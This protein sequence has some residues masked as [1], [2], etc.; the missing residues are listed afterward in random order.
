MITDVGMPEM[1]GWQLAERIKGTYSGMKVAVVTGWGADASDEEKEKYGVAYILG[2][3][4]DMAQ[5]KH[6]VGELLQLKEKQAV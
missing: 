2:K 1:R 6:V 4:V 3:P 5:L